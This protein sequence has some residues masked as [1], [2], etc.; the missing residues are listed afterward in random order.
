MRV[1]ASLGINHLKAVKA[2]MK[3]TGRKYDPDLCQVR[4]LLEMAMDTSHQQL[5]TGKDV[6]MRNKSRILSTLT[7]DEANKSK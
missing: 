4:P 1:A 2:K 5:S 3:L 6:S 7:E